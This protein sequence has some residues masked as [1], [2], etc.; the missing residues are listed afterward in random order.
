M[1]TVSGRI[2]S[3]TRA[4]SVI[5]PR[6]DVTVTMSPVTTPSRS[7]WRMDLAQGSGYCS[8]R[9]AM[10]RVWVPDRYATTRPVVSQIGYSSSTTSADS[11]N[12]TAWKRARPSG[13]AK[14]P[15]S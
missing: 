9:A 3:T 15:P 6:R 13:W 7:A 1:N 12:G 8:T 4:G 10:R 5:D 2:D 14:T 11:R